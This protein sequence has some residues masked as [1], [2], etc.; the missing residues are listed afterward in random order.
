MGL[1]PGP[2]GDWAELPQFPHR[3]R[4]LPQHPPRKDVMSYDSHSVLRTGLAAQKALQ[5]GLARLPP[6][7]LP[8]G[9]T[10]PPSRLPN[11]PQSHKGLLTEIPQ[12]SLRWV[13]IPT[14]E[15]L[16]LL[17]PQLP[18]LAAALAISRLHVGTL[19]G[20][21]SCAQ[22][23]TRRGGLSDQEPTFHRWAN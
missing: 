9:S 13:S 18:M 4:W 7:G 6:L 15:L 20:I 3:S 12:A 22:H 17:D 10:P 5:E 21:K 23:A 2:S 14:S 1:D 19:P 16:P 11:G 8:R